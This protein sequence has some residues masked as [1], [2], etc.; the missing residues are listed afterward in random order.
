MDDLGLPSRTLRLKT[1]KVR[2]TE[3]SI[4]SF[5][6]KNEPSTRMM[7]AKEAG[8]TWKTADKVIKDLKARRLLREKGRKFKTGL[9]SP[10]Y[11]VDF[12]GFLYYLAYTN[13]E[14][15]VEDAIKN[16]R[17]EN[18]LKVFD[19][20]TLKESLRL[21]GKELNIWL[22]YSVAAY[23]TVIQLAT[24]FE[25]QRLRQLLFPFSV[26]MKFEEM[27]TFN[28]LLVL[29]SVKDGIIV[30]KPMPEFYKELQPILDKFKKSYEGLNLVAQKFAS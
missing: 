15:D 1:G 10:L 2:K 12:V 8:L 17:S 9:H 21:D 3:L 5:L 22:M 4:V 7:I 13:S 19:F 18:D 24:V 14:R 30:A 28:F 11:T 20:E 27:F 23:E 25:D 26:L 6:A 29:N 16:Y